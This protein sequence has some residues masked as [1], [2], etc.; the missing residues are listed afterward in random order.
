MINFD[1]SDEKRIEIG[2]VLER[3]CPNIPDKG[4]EDFCK[5]WGQFRE[6]EHLDWII[7][8]CFMKGETITEDNVFMRDGKFTDD[9]VIMRLGD[10]WP[11]ELRGLSPDY[12]AQKMFG[13]FSR[14]AMLAQMAICVTDF[15]M[16]T[17]PDDSSLFNFVENYCPEKREQFW[18][19]L[20]IRKKFRDPKPKCKHCSHCIEK[21]KNADRVPIYSCELEGFKELMAYRNK[22]AAHRNLKYDPYRK[23]KDSGEEPRPPKYAT[24]EECIQRILQAMRVVYPEM[25][26]WIDRR[27]CSDIPDRSRSPNEWTTDSGEPFIVQNLKELVIRRLRD[28]LAWPEG[29]AQRCEEN[30]VRLKGELREIALRGIKESTREELVVVDVVDVDILAMRAKEDE[31]REA[32]NNRRAVQER[33]AKKRAEIERIRSS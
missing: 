11:E 4:K 8:S 5:L 9:N 6:L 23:L 16:G 31:I 29:L 28:S 33:I 30:L 25:D 27:K 15:I 21:L 17:H 12:A 2:K 13:L 26:Y 14:S 32:K 7:R 20:N 1:P 24:I 19:E 3:S 22:R 18:A 10:T